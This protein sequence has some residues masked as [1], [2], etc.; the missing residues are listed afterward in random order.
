MLERVV[1]SSN[2]RRVPWTCGTSE[3]SERL[4][5]GCSKGAEVKA[6]SG[7]SSST[8]A[9][10]AISAAKAR[11]RATGIKTATMTAGVWWRVCKSKSASPD[12]PESVGR[13][14]CRRVRVHSATRSS[15]SH[16]SSSSD[17]VSSR[18]A[19]GCTKLRRCLRRE[20]GSVRKLGP[21]MKAW[22]DRLT[23]KGREPE[24]PCRDADVVSRNVDHPVRRERCDPGGGNVSGGQES[25]SF[26]RESKTHQ[27]GR[28]DPPENDQ[29]AEQVLIVFLDPVRPAVDAVLPHFRARED[30][31]T[32]HRREVVAQQG[33]RSDA[34]RRQGLV[35]L[36]C[37][38]ECREKDGW[39]SRSR[40]GARRSRH[41]KAHRQGSKGTWTRG[42]RT[43][44]GWGVSSRW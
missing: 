20:G 22:R 10:S 36:S 43:L 32:E 31:R 38:G 25:S 33:S 29:V 12:T 24:L 11:R 28:G 26:S 2:S 21:R 44:E 5:R 9:A 16:P 34:L 23:Q 3:S 19:C 17:R 30:C 6:A 7:S 40:R 14:H 15:E 42:P 27:Q 13:T 39:D 37:H 1:P 35:S 4:A 8:A 18:S 41:P